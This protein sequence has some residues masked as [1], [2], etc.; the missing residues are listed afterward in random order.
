ML[1]VNVSPQGVKALQ[2]RLASSQAINGQAAQLHVL[3]GSLFSG[4][5]LGVDFPN[6]LG[7]QKRAVRR[8]KK[9]RSTRIAPTLL[10]S[11]G[12]QAHKR[13]HS[14]FGRPVKLGQHRADTGPTAS[15]L[16]GLGNPTG[17]ALPRI[18]P[19]GGSND[20][21]N[22]G[23]LVHHSGHARKELA[24]AYAGNIRRNLIKLSAYLLR[25]IGL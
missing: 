20:G 3:F 8:A 21:T 25:S 17:L 16:V 18:V 12:L 13:G 19:D 9:T 15:G 5:A 2:E 22:H 23:E 10:T 7:G 11:F 4:L 1:V 14:N 24:D 6:V